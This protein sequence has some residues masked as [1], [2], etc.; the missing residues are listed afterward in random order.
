MVFAEVNGIELYYE[1]HGEGNPIILANGIFMNTTSW[2]GQTPEFSK[3]YKV[4]LYDMRG[5]GQSDKP[6]G[7][8]SFELHAE[9]QK[10]LLEHLGIEKIHHVGIS[11]GAEL[12]LVFALKY[13]E[14]LKSLVLSSCVSHIG[15]FLDKIGN[16]WRYA[17]VKND[18]DLFFHSTILFNFS[19]SFISNNPEFFKVAIDRYKLLNLS[20][21]VKLMDAFQKLNITERLPEIKVPTLIIAG[22]K[23]L[24]KPP[25]PYSQL[26]HEGI[27]NSEL[28]IIAD[29]GH[30]VTHEKPDEFNTFVLDFLKD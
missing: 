29:T 13:P 17:C 27:H 20:P 4:I 28:K 7:D 21:F 12:G 18:P 2:F 3:H 23:D 6:E 10:A 11:Y 8:Y 25:I 16:L 19:E 22:E 1:I 26:I 9:D 24:L 30:A 5:Q 15:P 14:M